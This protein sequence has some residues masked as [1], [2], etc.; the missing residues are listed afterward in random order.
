[1]S[2][3]PAQGGSSSKSLCSPSAAL[4]FMPMCCTL[5]SFSFQWGYFLTWWHK[6]RFWCPKWGC[7]QAVQRIDVGSEAWWCL[8]LS[9][10]VLQTPMEGHRD[11]TSLSYK[12][13]WIMQIQRRHSW[14]GWLGLCTAWSSS[15][16][17]VYSMGLEVDDHGG[18]F[19]PKTFSNNHSRLFIHGCTPHVNFSFCTR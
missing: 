19:Q 11:A 1:M 17:P 7:T 15:W 6:Y 8:H 2:S 14:P 18:S 13:S 5:L 3:A 16:Q 9:I 12:R 10:H 4:S